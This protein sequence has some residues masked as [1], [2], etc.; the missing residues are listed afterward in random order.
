M[1]KI[2]IDPLQNI[3]SIQEQFNKYFPYLKIEFFREP[4]I[5]GMANAKNKILPG[6]T[7]ISEVRKVYGEEYLTFENDNTVNYLEKT[8]EKK[9]GMFAQVFRKSGS[10][11]LE[12]SA[13]DNWTLL[14]QNE[15]GALL[16]K[17]FRTGNDNLD[18]PND[19]DIY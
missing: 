4:H 11:W 1:Y 3:E 2:K 13:T 10:A 8:F 16:A 7:S 9:F 17:H 18:N 5:A 15:E 6:R 12:T 19:H 14:Q